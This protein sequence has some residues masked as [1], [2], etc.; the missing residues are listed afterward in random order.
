M[1]SSRVDI[2]DGIYTKDELILEISNNTIFNNHCHIN[3]NKKTGIVDISATNGNNIIKFWDLSH[4][5]LPFHKE[6][7]IEGELQRRINRFELIKK[8]ASLIIVGTDFF[9]I[10]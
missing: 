7:R 10:T 5:D 6:F 8:N 9:A 4:E 3:Y 2:S 1:D